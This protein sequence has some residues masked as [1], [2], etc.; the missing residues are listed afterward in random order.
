MTKQKHTQFGTQQ[1]VPRAVFINVVSFLP[2]MMPATLP[3]SNMT[4]DEMVPDTLDPTHDPRYWCLPPQRD[5]PSEETPRG[6]F[7]MY[8]VTQGRKVGVWHDWWVVPIFFHGC[9]P[10]RQMQ[11]G[12]EAHGERLS[13]GCATRSPHHER[14][15]P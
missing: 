8:L 11:D 14:V 5:E 4:E 12:G 9:R 15:R 3:P 7:P 1:T 6:N 2:P 13:I 10:L